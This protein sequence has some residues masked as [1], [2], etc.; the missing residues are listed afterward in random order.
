MIGIMQELPLFLLQTVLFPGAP[1]DLYIFEDRYKQMIRECIDEHRPFG[2][3]LVEEGMET[4][5]T[6]DA[7]YTVGCMAQIVQVESLSEGRMNIVVVGTER[8]R[9][10]ALSYERPYLVGLVELYPFANPTPAALTTAINRLRPWLARYLKA[11]ATAN[12]FTFDLSQLPDDPAALAFLAAYLLQ[13]PPEQKQELLSLPNLLALVRD[14]EALY[15]REV[16]LLEAQQSRGIPEQQ[17]P[18]SAN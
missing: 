18:F 10:T 1:L 5:D 8:F 7:I 17:G 12:R 3:V 2:I 16:T 9:V 11:L 14:T 6:P 4:E 13:I 15:R